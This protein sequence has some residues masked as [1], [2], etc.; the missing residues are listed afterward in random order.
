MVESASGGHVGSYYRPLGDGAYEPTIHVEG[1]WNPREQHMAPVSGLL[2]H[3][4]ESHEPREGMQLARV[5]YEILGMIPAERSEVTVRTVRPGRTI[6]LVEAT[7]DA[8]GR[9][10]VRARAWRLAT[11][12]SADVAGGAA[13]PLPD[14]E[15]MPVWDGTRTWPGGYISS[16]EGRAAT[17]NVPGRGQVWLRTGIGLIEGVEVSPTAAFLGLVD[18]ANGIVVR[19][20]P[21][22][23]MFPNVELSVHL[24]RRPVPGWVGFDTR[25]VIDPDGIGLTASTLHD[26]G[27]PVGRSEQ[28]L[29]VRRL[30]E[31]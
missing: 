28:L 18:T 17:G 23:W 19:A 3:A 12:D 6:E 2:A 25:V 13:D 22:A 31:G 21:R 24:H 26:I 30:P 5:T 4:I 16:L 14:P 20:D 10:V 11:H 29:T 9:T 15:S 1:A 27:G 8:G 7:L